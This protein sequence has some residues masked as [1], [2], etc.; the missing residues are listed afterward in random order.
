MGQTSATGVNVP[1]LDGFPLRKAD[2]NDKVYGPN[3]IL[4][5]EQKGLDCQVVMVVHYKVPDLSY[6]NRLSI[7]LDRRLQLNDGRC[8]KLHRHVLAKADTHIA[9]WEYPA[10]TLEREIRERR[11]SPLSFVRLTQFFPDAEV[12]TMIRGLCKESVK[13]CTKMSRYHGDI[14][15]KFIMLNPQGEVYL[16][17]ILTFQ[18]MKETAYARLLLEPYY[19]CCQGPQALQNVEQGLQQPTFDA[20][21]NDVFSIAVSVLAAICDVP[22]G[23]DFLKKLYTTQGKKV[24]IEWPEIERLLRG[25]EDKGRSRDLVGALRIMLAKEEADRPSLYQV[26]E[27]VRL[28]SA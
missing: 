5:S 10:Y 14:Q 24:V 2:P 7:L 26:L 27:F 13:F 19:L 22:A 3:D 21:K 4:F 6:A 25:L 9:Y 11:A 16:N 1:D 12:W 23:D 18:P 15:P 20:N 8:L 28:V 17:D